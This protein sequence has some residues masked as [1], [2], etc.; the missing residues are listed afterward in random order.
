MPHA[1]RL[2]RHSKEAKKILVVDDYSPTRN[3]IIEALGQN[4]QYQTKEAET[5]EE[6]LRILDSHSFDLIISDIMMPGMSG[7]ELLHAVRQRDP[8]VAVIMIT[9]NPTTD[10]TVSAI[11]LTYICVGGN[12][13]SP[14]PVKRSLPSSNSMTKPKHCPNRA[15]FLTPLKN[16]RWTMKSSSRR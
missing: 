12:F 7:M 15:I 11:K 5:G 1:V 10:L 6:A 14:R 9:G 8:A 2:V 16:L 4:P 3:L 13:L